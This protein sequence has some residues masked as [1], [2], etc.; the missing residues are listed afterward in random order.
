[1]YG[2]SYNFDNVAVLDFSLFSFVFK[3][4]NLAKSYINLSLYMYLV[5]L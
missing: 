1:M 2:A 5:R 4:G 3:F